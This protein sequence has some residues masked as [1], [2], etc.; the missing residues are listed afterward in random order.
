MSVPTVLSLVPGLFPVQVR[1]NKGCS[2]CSGNFPFG[3]TTM[4]AI[5]TFR[6]IFSC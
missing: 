1:R 6:R 2:H 3:R 5:E 4:E